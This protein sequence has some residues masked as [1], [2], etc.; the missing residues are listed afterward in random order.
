MIRYKLLYYWFRL[1]GFSPCTSRG[2]VARYITRNCKTSTSEI[3]D[4]L[5]SEI[6]DIVSSNKN[7]KY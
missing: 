1:K 2:K 6:D 4:E 7:R 5:N 3:L